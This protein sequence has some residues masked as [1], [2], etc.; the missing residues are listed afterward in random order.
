M[1]WFKNEFRQPRIPSPGFFWSQDKLYL[2]LYLTYIHLGNKEK[3]MDY[4]KMNLSSWEF[5]LW[6]LHNSMD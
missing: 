5:S 1:I 2:F 3:I 4:E 6:D